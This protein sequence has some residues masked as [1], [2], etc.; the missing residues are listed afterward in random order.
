MVH[1]R[2]LAPLALTLA[3]GPSDIVPTDDEVGDSTSTGVEESGGTD[4]AEPLSLDYLPIKQ[5][6]FAWQPV[7]GADTYRLYEQ[8]DVDEP[9]V[10]VG[11][12]LAGTSHS[13]TVPLHLRARARY[14]LH[15][16]EGDA[17]TLAAS[18]AVSGNLASAIGYVKASNT[19]SI[20][21]PAYDWFGFT[22]ALSGDGLTLA[23]AAPGECSNAT[24]VDG[25]QSDNSLQ[26]AGAVYVFRRS[27]ETWAQEAY[28][29]ASNPAVNDFFGDALALSWD[30]S[31][32]AVGA[33]F[34]DSAATGID[35]D[36]SNDDNALGGAVYVFE[37]G[38]SGWA[39]QAYVKPSNRGGR[40]GGA[41]AL[42]ASGDTLA[43][44]AIA[45]R[46][47][48]TG[49]DGDDSDESRWDA[50]AA[51]V[52]ERDAGGWAQQAYVKSSSTSSN[53]FFGACLALSSSGDRLVVGAPGD[54]Q[55]GRVYDFQRSSGTW[56][57]RVR[58]EAPTPV[59]DERFGT[60]VALSGE[61]DTL[62]IGAWDSRKTYVMVATPEGW[63]PHAELEH[64][65]D[66]IA[67]SSDGTTLAIG[68]PNASSSGAG[69][70]DTASEGD[71]PSGALE[72]YRRTDASWSAWS[73]VKASNPRYADEF[74]ASV[75][76]S[77]D[78]GTLVV[79]APGERGGATGIGGDQTSDVGAPAGAA[80]LY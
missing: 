48:A 76:L 4:D 37:R 54:G 45:E 47:A 49:I 67:L 38:P 17:C 35:G 41:L 22:V 30:G 23:V 19:E 25:D 18:V 42:S 53:D 59:L 50:G 3:C 61:G 55:V 44:G 14:E 58:I 21:Y 6:A 20:D 26:S 75:A 16:C 28:V 10:L 8:V 15:G 68:L 43:V 70:A 40:F 52:F 74:G 27:G 51:Y 13:L 66:A 57:E 12:A 72:L 29:K 1:A 69:V 71:V 32:L 11:D 80:Y 7:A 5:F 39:Q 60:A 64:F 9:L 36:Q 34:E 78:G 65:D 77:S 62:A 33:P 2:T 24:G 46:S 31:T 73:H 79:G 56:S 63:L